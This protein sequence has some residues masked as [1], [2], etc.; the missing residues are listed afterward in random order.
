MPGLAR[1]LAARNIAAIEQSGV[2]V[3]AVNSAGC[4]A[5]L[6]EYPE[7][8]SNNNDD[9]WAGRARAFAAKVKDVSEIVASPHFVPPARALPRTVTY[10][11][12]CHLAHGQRVRAEPRRL[13][14]SIP[15]IRFVEMREPDRCCGSAGIYNLLHPEVSQK[16]LDQK[17]ERVKETGAEILVTA[18]PGCLL[19]LEAGRREIGLDIEVVHLVDLLDRAYGPLSLTMPERGGH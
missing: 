15:G 10:Q 18:N 11:D 6:K 16:I 9:S 5:T 19:Q 12:P 14:R 2:D 3:V 13:L 4:G 7:L 8:F 17:M 1:Q